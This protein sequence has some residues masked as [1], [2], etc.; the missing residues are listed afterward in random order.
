LLGC[1]DD[2]VAEM[3][4]DLVYGNYLDSVGDVGDYVGGEVG[5]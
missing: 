5:E 1:G 3:V 4:S 2:A